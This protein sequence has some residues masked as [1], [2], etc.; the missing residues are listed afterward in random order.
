M[1][2][3]FRFERPRPLASSVRP[4]FLV[5]VFSP[6][7]ANTQRAVL[8]F[9]YNLLGFFFHLSFLASLLRVLGVF[10]L[11]AQFCIRFCF[12]F[13]GTET[14][15]RTATRHLSVFFVSPL[16]PPPLCLC[17][18]RK[19]HRKVVVVSRLSLYPPFVTVRSTAFAA[20]FFP[21]LFLL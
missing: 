9:F 11:F 3:Q 20:S 14:R 8:L 13:L 10:R 15:H 12:G 17:R 21:S 6:L 18:V 19:L 4:G 16:P 5:C 1:F 2:F 7:C